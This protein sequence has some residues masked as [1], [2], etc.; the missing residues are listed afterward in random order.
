MIVDR[1]TLERVERL[2]AEVRPLMG[3]NRSRRDRWTRPLPSSVA[4]WPR[5]RRARA[6]IAPG[7]SR[8]TRTGTCG[9]RM[10]LI[11]ASGIT[12]SG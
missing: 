2:L 10:R 7:I 6:A 5:E 12:R 9:P 3:S 4:Y 8:P 1:A 11:G